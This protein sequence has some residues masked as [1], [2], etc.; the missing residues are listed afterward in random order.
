MKNFF[1][2]LL[3]LLFVDTGVA[4]SN[5]LDSLMAAG[6]F[7]KVIQMADAST[8]RQDKKQAFLVAK[9]YISLGNAKKA[10]EVY[11]QNL[12]DGD[13]L[14]HFYSYGKVLLQQDQTKLADSIFSYLHEQN[15]KNAEFLY[16]L[17][18]AKQKL[19]D[20]DFK[21]TLYKAYDL[22]QNHLLVTY[23]LAK[24]EL[25][26]KNYA[27]AIRVASQGLWN[28]PENTS[29]LSIKGQ[30]LYSRGKWKDCISTFNQLKELTDVPLFVEL[31]LAKAH[32]NLRNYP[33]ALAHYKTCLAKDPTD[34]VLF[35]DAAEVATLCEETDLALLYIS[36][37][38][39]LKDVSR[40]RQLYIFGTVFLQKEDYEK[41]IGL[42]TQC[43]EED[44]N[45]E[46]ATYALANAKDRF[47]A[48]QEKILEAYELY[49]QNFPD[50]KYVDLADYRVKELRK[51][52]FLAGKN[53]N[54][55]E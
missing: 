34:H 50:G 47:Y 21:K 42:F 51:E 37:A 2:I 7:A 6:E 44:A 12:E 1:S 31:R 36:Q 38:Y 26:Q 17:A 49:L 8:E 19:N 4:Q 39:A 40:A 28:N 5:M 54:E 32:V 45:Q 3:I 43:I 27:V 35:E 25:K 9:A 22:Q 53:Q 33:E 30:A 14:Q 52:V 11:Q 24:E 15:P 29:L 23:E 55:K 18:L 46:K 16:R 13:Q 20:D 41:A 48:D 10:S